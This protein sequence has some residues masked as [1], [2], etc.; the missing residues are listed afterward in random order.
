MTTRVGLLTD[1]GMLAH[2]SA[3]LHPERPPRLE[4][5]QAALER[6]GLAARMTRLP[7]TPATEADLLLCHDPAHLD[8]V[9][10]ACRLT[11]PLTADTGAGPASWDAA[12]LAAGAGI[13]AANAILD[14][15]ITRAFCAGRP[16]GHHANRTTAQGFCLFNNVAIAARHLVER[17]GLKKV[18]IVDFD[19]H[20]GNGTQDIFYE[21]GSVLFCSI[22]QWG[23][24]PLNPSHAFYPGTGGADETGSGPGKGLTL[25]VPLAAGSG[26]REF[27]EAFT[28]TIAPA[29]RAF[30]PEL[31]LISAGFDAHKEDPLGL[32]ELE[33]EDYATLTGRL[34]DVADDVC[35]G[36]VLSMLEGGYHLTALAAGTAAHVETLLR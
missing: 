15:K 1:P 5:V 12:K 18:A 22:H 27:D 3:P 8:R 4:A 23:P 29:L 7:I 25:N 9:R 16:P 33:S 6:A 10:E 24:N 26:L 14:G 28:G 21:D 17:R 11:R 36:R 19:V 35:A 2:V 32:C 20:H 31:L 34:I 13:T 30:R